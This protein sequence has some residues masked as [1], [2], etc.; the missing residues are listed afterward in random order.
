[1]A[2]HEYYFCFLDLIVKAKSGTGKTAVFG[3]I[4]LETIDVTITSPQVLILAPTREIAIQIEHVLKAIGVNIKGR[5]NQGFWGW[6][7]HLCVLK[8]G[9]LRV[10]CFRQTCPKI[11]SF[12]P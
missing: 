7:L 11:P 12:G 4:A 2:Y 5:Y 8:I 10:L 1:M 3:I 9:S 6:F